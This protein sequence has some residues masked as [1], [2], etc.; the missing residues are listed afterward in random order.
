MEHYQMYNA[1]QDCQMNNVLVTAGICQGNHMMNM[2]SV[3]IN[4]QVNQWANQANSPALY[5]IGTIY[6]GY[7]ASTQFAQVQMYP[8]FQGLVY[9]PQFTLADREH[10]IPDIPFHKM[11]VEDL[12]IWVGELA[13]SLSWTEAGEYTESFRQKEVSGEQILKM[14]SKTLR[15]D[16]N[17]RKLG[18]RLEILRAVKELVPNPEA[19]CAEAMERYQS[20]ISTYTDS[21]TSLV[22]IPTRSAPEPSNER[23]IQSEKK[24]RSVPSSGDEKQVSDQSPYID[25]VIPSILNQK[26]GRKST[27]ATPDVKSSIMIKKRKSLEAPFME[28]WEEEADLTGRM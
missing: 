1:N 22:G 12:A 5:P 25:F 4:Y 28:S 27:V 8:N 26:G 24:I 13:S 9:S 23:V 3:P 16:L 6:N 10:S 2:A 20:T 11:N 7:P 19:Q 15:D 17:I 14:D 18:H 21:D